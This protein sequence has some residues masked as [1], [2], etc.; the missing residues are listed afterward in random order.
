MA[1]QDFHRH[2]TTLARTPSYQRIN[3]RIARYLTNNEAG[4]ID[5]PIRYIED[6]E[7]P[8]FLQPLHERLNGL[9]TMKELVE[10]AKLAKQE[11]SIAI[12]LP[13]EGLT[14][15]ERIE[16]EIQRSSAFWREPKDLVI[17][18]VICGI[19][20]MA[21]GWDQV[22][23]GNLGWTDTFQLQID[24]RTEPQYRGSSHEWDTHKFAAVQAVPWFSAAILGPY[25]SDPLSEFTGRRPAL[26]VSALFSLISSIAGS[27]AS[28]W[29][30]LIG[31][32]VL[33]GLG[34]GGKASIVPVLASEILPASKRGRLLVGWQVFNAAGIFVGS[35]A[36]YILRENW[37]N[38]IISGAVP[39]LV[40]ALAVAVACESPRWLIVHGQYP[41]AFA[42]LLRLRKERRLALKEL[43]SVHYQTQAER[44][45]F[46]RPRGRDKDDESGPHIS[47]FQTD[48]GRTSWWERLHNM[49]YIQRIRRAAIAAMIVMLAQQLSGINIYAFLSTHFYSTLG[50]PLGP[51]N[52]TV[53]ASAECL[54]NMT[55]GGKFT[56]GWYCRL[57][58]ASDYDNVLCSNIFG[59]HT[60]DSFEEVCNNQS[61]NEAKSF[62][63][64]IGF[65]FAN[66]VFSCLAYFLVE[67]QEPEDAVTRIVQA[68]REASSAIKYFFT[69]NLD[70]KATQDAKAGSKD[71]TQGTSNKASELVTLSVE[72][73]SNTTQGSSDCIQTV[74][75]AE[76]TPQESHGSR[77]QARASITGSTHSV[78]EQY[79]TFPEYGDAPR[80][81]GRRFLLLTSLAGGSI[82]LLLTSMMFYINDSGVRERMIT[83]F[84]FLF[85][86]INAPGA[87][88][89]PFLYCAEIFPNEGR[90]LGMSWAIF[91][92]FFGAGSVALMVPFGIDYGHREILAIFAGLSAVAFIFVYFCVFTTNHTTS[93]EDYSYVFGKKMT[94]HIKLQARRLWFWKD[95]P[96]QSFVWKIGTDGG[97]DGEQ[98]T[99]DTGSDAE[100]S[101]QSAMERRYN[102]GPPVL[103]D[104]R[105]LTS[106][107]SMEG[108]RP[109]NHGE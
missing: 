45:L 20:A 29:Q 103:P 90:E 89:I 83:L 97:C 27:R 39:A 80:F 66:M 109:R 58:N 23:N 25:L 14:E 67:N 16:M 77:N 1:E 79:E 84:I 82:T 7:L 69:G 95:K 11:H 41:K 108:Y 85:T 92:N 5:H 86:A 61:D 4:I 18:L 65:G 37:R 100:P 54:Y 42:T 71:C 91:W 46:M 3:E 22:A 75:E 104:T 35:I 17:T 68:F 33:L 96:A 40:L 74:T 38:Q 55:D 94:D 50:P 56:A 28:S 19:A 9:V 72:P 48:L 26:F 87:G 32:R 102:Q 13:V 63:F 49:I 51:D 6:H 44:G 30:R 34:I 106:W 43:V 24:P 60:T 98:V 70:P 21:Q 105:R 36:C 57:A 99:Y 10:S 107:S 62:K 88:V 15:A 73:H 12:G 31:I 52:S 101:D 78:T 8:L 93:L 53:Y 81:R 76:A 64:A 2:R 59:P 47:P